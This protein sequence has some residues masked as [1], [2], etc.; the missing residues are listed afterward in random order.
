MTMPQ[1]R[2]LPRLAL[3]GVMLAGT[4]PLVAQ[5]TP[6]A[7][8]AATSATPD[9]A[10]GK[11]GWHK[12]KRGDRRP[13]GMFAGLSE[14]GRATM[15][16]AM[17]AGG[18]P[19]SDRDAVK[20]ARDRMLTVLDADRLDAGALK[21]AMDD[22]RQAA[23]VGHDKRQAAMLAGFTK[24]STADRKAFV[25]NARAMKDRMEARIGK[26]RGGRG[27]GDMPPPPM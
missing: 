24:L 17:K 21:R 2:G 23:Q 15:R 5:T 6:A 9:R 18:D 20:A 12:G 11:P 10:A 3:I 22:E 8:S 7:P 19:R 14:A 25:A 1:L 26:M 16:D 27:P 13:G 4:A